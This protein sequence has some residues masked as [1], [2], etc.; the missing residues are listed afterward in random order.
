MAFNSVGRSHEYLRQL[1]RQDILEC[2]LCTV[3]TIDLSTYTVSVCPIDNPD[4]TYYDIFL[5]PAMSTANFL[6]IPTI[7]STVIVSFISNNAGYIS[8]YSSI[9]QYVISNS[10]DTLG[11]ILTNLI[12]TILQITL[13]TDQGP[14]LTDG[15]INQDAFID[16]QTRLKKLFLK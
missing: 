5:S 13:L 2:K 9:D 1:T 12:D 11:A 14:T 4:L 6:I 8:M 10:S 16:L 3:L 15:V 7:N